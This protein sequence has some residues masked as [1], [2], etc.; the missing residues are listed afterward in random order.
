MRFLLL[1][2][3]FSLLLSIPCEAAPPARGVLSLADTN[4]YGG[5]GIY[6]VGRLFYF[7]A[8]SEK[9]IPVRLNNMDSVRALPQWNGYGRFQ[10]TV[11]ADSAFASKIWI[12]SYFSPE[13]DR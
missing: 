6:Q 4:R 13:Q 5:I 9:G 10:A 2:F 1:S 7:P 3:G 8:G 11:E 12:A